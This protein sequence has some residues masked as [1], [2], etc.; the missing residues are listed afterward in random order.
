M[1]VTSLRGPTSRHSVRGQHSF[2]QKNVAA[3]ASRWQY[4]VRFETQL[5]A[6]ETNALP[7]DQLAGHMKVVL[8]NNRKQLDKIKIRT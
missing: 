4:C 5:P 6:P 8:A 1:R 7:L 2:F 3:V